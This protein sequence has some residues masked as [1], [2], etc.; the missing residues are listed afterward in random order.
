MA[1]DRTAIKAAN[2]DPTV[3]LVLAALAD[4]IDP[5]SGLVTQITSTTTGVTL[6]TAS[7]I[8]TTFSQS[9]AAGVS[10]TFT[11]TNSKATAGGN[12]RAVVVDYAG[13]FTT[14]GLPVVSVDNRVAGA[15]DIVVSNAHSANALSGALQ[16]GFEIVS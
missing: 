11:V 1:I 9:A 8:I 14:N 15:F 2:I 10:A 4:M 6:N 13:V 5:T 3:K 12:I 7:G 16:I